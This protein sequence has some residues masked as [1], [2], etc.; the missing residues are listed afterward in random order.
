MPESP[1]RVA[2][3]PPPPPPGPLKPPLHTLISSHDFAAAAS[4]FP[5]KTYAFIS[6]A[7]TDCLT[8]RANTT[9]YAAIGL[10]PRVLRD[11]SGPVDLG[12]SMLGR[13]VRSP[14]F[15]SP[16]S[17]GTLVHPDGECALGRACQ[18]LGIAQ[19]VSTS[20][21]FPLGD[22]VDAIRSSSTPAPAAGSDSGGD[23]IPIFFQLYVDKDRAKSERL[24]AAAAA[25]G[26]VGGVF[27]TVDAPVMG[28]RE[29]DERVRADES[30]RAPMAG[31]RAGNDG[32]GGGLG[33]IMGQYVD[34]S[35]AWADLAWLRRCL[36]PGTPVALKGV[37]TAA[38]AVRA[39]DAG[40]DAIFVSNHGGRSLDTAP[41]TILVLLE[42][43]RCCPHVFDRVQVF[44]DGGVARGTDVFKAL[45][46]GATAVGV[47][48][49][50]LYGL[51][52]GEEG[53]RRYIEILNEELETTMRLCGVTSL[54]ELHPGLLNTRAVDHLVPESA[55]DDH[56]YAKWRRKPQGSKL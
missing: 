42:L 46:L 44:V 50:V 27:L 14:I 23:M 43:Q 48:R 45:C 40:V 3:P 10:R 49:G 2:S 6:S 8:H 33:R 9:A 29:A 11:V 52:Y 12:T 4:A 16:T 24:L 26:C 30:V 5:A 34:A 56:P 20:A 47:G 38:D 22:I 39:V 1:N 37:Q 54:D 51:N 41:A 28:K 13:H 21:S 18:A 19:V 25:L 32:G 35:V 7:A 36:P 31:T 17:L 53:V 15:C 55:A